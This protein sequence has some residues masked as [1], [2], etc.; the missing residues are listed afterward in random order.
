MFED[1]ESWWKIA[2]FSSPLKRK[3]MNRL[4]TVSCKI[5]YRK[6]YC[7]KMSSLEGRKISPS[8]HNPTN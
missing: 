4:M 1:E 6:R 7:K 5:S 8:V 2:I 3:G